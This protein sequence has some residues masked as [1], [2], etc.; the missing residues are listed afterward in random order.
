[1][2]SYGDLFLHLKETEKIF[3][4]DFTFEQVENWFKSNVNHNVNVENSKCTKSSWLIKFFAT[5]KK[6]SK[7]IYASSNRHVYFGRNASVDFFLKKPI[8]IEYEDCSCL[9]MDTSEP[10][11]APEPIVASESQCSYRFIAISL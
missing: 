1:M 8:L 2:P 7:A 9:P 5:F 6:E 4:K 10:I 3:P 11:N